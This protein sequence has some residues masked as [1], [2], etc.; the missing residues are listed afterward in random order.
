MNAYWPPMRYV[1]PAADE[2]LPLKTILRRR[3]GISRTLL[4]RLKTTEKGLMINGVRA[5]ANA[6]VRAGDRVEVRLERERSDDIVPEPMPLDILYEDDFLLVVN[7]PPGL[8]VHPT[9]GHYT[10]TLANAVVHYWQ[11]KGEIVRF[12]PIHRLDQGTSG[13]LAIAKNPYIHQQ[14]A[15]QMKRGEVEKTYAAFV[16]GEPS[17]PSGTINAPIDRDRTNPH[18]RIVTEHGYPAVTHYETVQAWGRAA[19]LRVRLE[20]GRTHQIRVHLKHIGCPLIGDAM[21]GPDDMTEER[22]RLHSLL[23]R[24]AL[25]AEE[26]AVTHPA[27]GQRLRFQAPLPEDLSGLAQLFEAMKRRKE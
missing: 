1:V 7:K 6:T 5:Y 3:M 13:V 8:I 15:E 10:G 18:I 11:S 16:H 25:H 14:I 23:P 20:T 26:L 9:H 19:R 22:L 21:Y 2:G 17:P 24:Q 4:T 12:R 27:N